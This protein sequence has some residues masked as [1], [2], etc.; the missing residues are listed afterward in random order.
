MSRWRRLEDLDEC[1]F[2][3]AGPPG[4]IDALLR[5]VMRCGKVQPERIF[6]DRFY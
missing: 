4:L 3:M 2:Y 5:P 6:F 1:D